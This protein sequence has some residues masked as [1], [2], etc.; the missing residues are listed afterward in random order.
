MKETYWPDLST[1]SLLFFLNCLLGMIRVTEIDA[2]Q[3]SESFSVTQK[4]LALE[5][6]SGS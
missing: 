5:L 4:R 2:L 1:I 6:P 3:M